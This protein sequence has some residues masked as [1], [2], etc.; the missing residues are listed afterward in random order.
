ARLHKPFKKPAPPLPYFRIGE[1]RK[2]ASARPYIA[3]HKVVVAA[4]AE[5]MVFFA[6]AEYPVVVVDLDARVDDHYR[7]ETVV[8]QFLDHALGGGKMVLVPRKA[9]VSV[10]IVDVEVDGV[11]GDLACTEIAGQVLDLTLRVV[12]PA[13]L[14]VPQGPHRRQVMRARERV[15]TLHDVDHVRAVDVI[16][17]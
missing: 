6:F 2:L 14:V 9:A 11:A 4:A 17:L 1:I 12:A 16:V 3:F 10:H 8:R 13:A 7:T 15:V 5:E